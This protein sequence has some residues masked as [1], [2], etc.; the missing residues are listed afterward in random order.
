MGVQFSKNL[1]YLHK[2]LQVCI[3]RACMV[4]RAQEKTRSLLFTVMIMW[5]FITQNCTDECMQ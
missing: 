3:D 5:L 4:N 2:Q 1:F